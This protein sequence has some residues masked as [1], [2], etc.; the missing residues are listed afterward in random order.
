MLRR[1]AAGSQIPLLELPAGKAGGD[2]QHMHMI[3]VSVAMAECQLE[4]RARRQAELLQRHLNQFVPLRTCKPGTKRRRQS[5]VDEGLLVLARP[6]QRLDMAQRGGVVA[7]RVGAPPISSAAAVVP[8]NG[9]ARWV[10]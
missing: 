2:D 4:Q 10:R 1:L 3:A 8:A 7:P 9:L 6:G 5:H